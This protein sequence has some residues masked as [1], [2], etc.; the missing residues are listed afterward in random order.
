[1]AERLDENDLVLVIVSGGGSSLLCWPE[2]ECEQ[3]RRLYE[4]FLR[5]G[6]TKFLG[7]LLLVRNFLPAEHRELMDELRLP[8]QMIGVHPSGLHGIF[9]PFTP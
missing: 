3:G 7:G 6:G 9:D 4:D 8:E 5:A 2:S 1:M